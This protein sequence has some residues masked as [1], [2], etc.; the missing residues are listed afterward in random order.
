MPPHF[1]IHTPFALCADVPEDVRAWSVRWAPLET[2]SLELVRPFVRRL[3]RANEGHRAP[4]LEEAFARETL[5]DNIARGAVEPD[6]GPDFRPALQHRLIDGRGAADDRARVFAWVVL[7]A[8]RYPALWLK[9]TDTVLD[10][11]PEPPTAE[12]LRLMRTAAFGAAIAAVHITKLKD[13]ASRTTQTGWSA[14]AAR[15][16]HALGDHL[17]APSAGHLRACMDAAQREYTRFGSVWPASPNEASARVRIDRALLAA[18]TT[19]EEHP[20][21]VRARRL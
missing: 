9:A 2:I 21:P 20:D 8:V 16:A 6:F 12:H 10:A 15:L 18:E 19:T 3:D 1:N 11:C 4:R 7:R 13:A 17:D 14:H 5:R